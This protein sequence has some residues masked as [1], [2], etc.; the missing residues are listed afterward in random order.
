MSSKEGQVRLEWKYADDFKRVYATNNFTVIGD[1]DARIFFGLSSP[2]MQSD[3]TSMPKG[4]GEY[5]V[6]I[7]LPFRALKELVINLNT[8]VK[9]AEARFGEIRLPKRPEDLFKQP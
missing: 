5:K 8:M 3:P 9:D 6:E 4:G 2:V 7:I 1:Y